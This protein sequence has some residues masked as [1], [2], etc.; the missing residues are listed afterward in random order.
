MAPPLMIRSPSALTIVRDTA[1]ATTD[2]QTALQVLHSTSLRSLMLRDVVVGQCQDDEQSGVQRQRPDFDVGDDR[3]ASFLT[4]GYVDQ[5][6][7]F[8]SILLYPAN[9]ARI[10]N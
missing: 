1:I 8:H 3:D 4:K 9:R 2:A 10:D 5:T 7:I 6:T